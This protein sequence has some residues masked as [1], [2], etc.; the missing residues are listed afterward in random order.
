M[1]HP[2]VISFFEN[3]QE[4][5]WISTFG[6]GLNYF[7][8]ATDQWKHYQ[9]NAGNKGASNRPSTIFRTEQDQFWIASYG[10]GLY[11]F[12]PQT[13]VFKNFNHDPNNPNSLSHNIVCPILADQTGTIWVGGNKG[14]L[15]R[16][17]RET[18]QFERISLG[19]HVWGLSDMVMDENGW[20]WIGSGEGLIHF[21]P[22]N[23]AFQI[24]TNVPNDSKSLSLSH[25]YTLHLDQQQQ[26]WIGTAG[27]GLN[28]L[29]DAEKGIFKKYRTADGLP[30]DV[31]YAIEPDEAGYFW[32]TTNQGISRFDPNAA[33]F[34]TSML[35]TVYRIMNLINGLFFTI[36]PPKEC[37]RVGSTVL[38]FFTQ[39]A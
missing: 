27:G 5:L 23:Y 39:I 19:A 25:V 30:N 22:Q 9:A 36:R 10:D 18:E 11:L 4:E 26:L 35:T 3:D 15:N 37:L 8:P 24:Y 14:L 6:G 12:D 21:N 13:E 20:F 7:N 31:V 1:S 32:L 28:L 29:L 38:I 17:D 33:L 16:F 2:H 34:S